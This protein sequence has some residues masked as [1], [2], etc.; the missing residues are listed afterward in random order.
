MDRVQRQENPTDRQHLSTGKVWK[1]PVPV[2]K[3]LTR[4]SHAPDTPPTGAPRPT[5]RT[6]A[7]D[8]R[9]GART[10]TD[11]RLFRS[12]PGNAPG[13]QLHARQLFS[14]PLCGAALQVD[15]D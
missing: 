4:P 14:P 7:R 13:G 11:G 6:G 5:G 15:S 10:Y 12:H 9:P 1:N 8:S 2:D 3:N